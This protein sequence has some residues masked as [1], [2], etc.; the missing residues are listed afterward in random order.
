MGA[1]PFSHIYGLVII[2]HTSAYRGDQ[3]I[4]L[5]KFE[6]SNF[7]KCI[8]LFKVFELFVVPPIVI[9]MMK[10]L[11]VCKAHDLSSV[12][13]VYNGAAL[14]GK[15]MMRDLQIAYPEW[16]VRQA[17]G[18]TEATSVVSAMSRADAWP[19]SSGS[20]LPGVEARIV[21]VEGQ[22]VETHNTPGELWIKG[23]NVALGYLNN[24]KA[25]SE[26]FIEDERGRWLKTGE[27]VEFRICPEDETEHLWVVDRIKELI[28]VKVNNFNQKFTILWFLVINI[29]TSVGSSS[30]SRGAGGA[31]PNTSLRR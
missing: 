21:T 11:E 10:N 9:T 3:V 15:E 25:T 7:L 28:K 14:L 19:G 1:L 2:C 24:E 17:Y 20:L 4:V 16:A 26:T 5:P 6:F 31:P 12:K 27:E 30:S 13:F 18:L 29:C 8:V 23:P 22:E